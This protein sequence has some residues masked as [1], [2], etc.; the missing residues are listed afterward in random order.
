MSTDFTF[1]FPLK[2]IRAQTNTNKGHFPDPSV[3]T[4]PELGVFRE[5]ETQVS[6]QTVLFKEVKE[7]YIL[8]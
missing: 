6:G 1:S 8:R 3:G 5:K 2:T 4:I 7:R